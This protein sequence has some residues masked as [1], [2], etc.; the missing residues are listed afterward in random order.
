MAQILV[1]DDDVSICRM[2]E[3]IAERAG[4]RALKATSLQEGLGVV[5]S[6]PVDIVFLDVRLPDGNGI[7]TISAIQGAD[8]SPE[9]I[10]ITG[11]AEPDGAELAIR[12][13][14]WD[15]I[16][17][18]FSFTE[19]LL[20]IQQVLRYRE[21]KAAHASPVAL[22]LTGIVGRCHKM[23]RAYDLLAKAAGSEAGVLLTGETGTGKELFARAIHDNSSR[24]KGPF[25]AVD[26]GALTETLVEST[27][28]GHAK[29]A[30]T[31]AST[32]RQGLFREADGGTI[33]LD[34]IGEL[35]PDVQKKLLR[36][37]QEGTF[38]PVGGRRDESSSFRLIAATNR[39]LERMVEMEAFRGDLL[40]RLRSI[41]IHLPP[42]REREGDIRDLAMHYM[43]I[44]CDRY[45]MTP[46]GFCPE[47][48]ESIT[49]YPWPGN[50]RELSHAMERAVSIAR[51]E[52]TL[53]RIHLPVH[54]RADMARK[55]LEKTPTPVPHAAGGGPDGLPPMREVVETAEKR[56][57]S[58]LMQA[59]GGDVREACVVSGLSRASLYSRLK[60]YG[61]SRKH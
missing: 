45:G 53:F 12:S 51:E 21:Q 54:I 3:R 40:Y 20:P 8:P 31:G 39:D 46:K 29:G 13:G 49:H 10:I 25:V 42:L 27:L 15:Y 56:Y 37:L 4:H 61:M 59:C 28:F 18:P 16:E 7:E 60:K 6:E 34:E 23:T 11:V 35:S 38:R 19:L 58:E 24:A 57:L 26:C 52:P 36:V 50:V 1:I 17:K 55:G 33:F 14:A 47:F 5:T 43:Q 30:F 32:A 48:F 9:V 2:V 22:K 44:Y 41:V